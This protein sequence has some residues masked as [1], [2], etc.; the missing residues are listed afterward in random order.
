MADTVLIT[1]TECRNVRQLSENYDSVKF[2]AYVLEVQRNYV[3]PL[4]GSSLYLDVIANPTSTNNA[5]LLNGTTYTKNGRTINFRGLKLYIIYLFFYLYV[6]EGKISYTEIGRENFESDW[7]T[8]K[9][10]GLNSSVIKQHFDNAQPLGE[11]VKAYLEDNY[12]DFPL[13][14]STESTTEQNNRLDYTVFGRSY[15]KPR[16]IHWLNLK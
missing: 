13:Y 2:N 1:N 11:S 6:K 7:S 8:F 15:N 4:L 5:K 3:E 14:E 12:S 10:N 9:E 16:V